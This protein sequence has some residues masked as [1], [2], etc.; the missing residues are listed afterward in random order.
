MEGPAGAKMFMD[1]KN[2]L[3]RA[4]P[5][6]GV[7]RVSLIKCKPNVA[8]AQEALWEQMMTGSYTEMMMSSKSCHQLLGEDSVPR[9][10]LL[11]ER[12]II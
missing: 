4:S 10:D 8:S 9:K 7:V 6:V 12:C 5:V 2:S 3:F 11:N 1:V